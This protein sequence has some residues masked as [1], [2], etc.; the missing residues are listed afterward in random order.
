MSHLKTKGVIS[1]EDVE[2]NVDCISR[3]TPTTNPLNSN[4]WFPWDTEP[5]SSLCLPPIR[6]KNHLLMRHNTRCVAAG[7]IWESVQWIAQPSMEQS[8]PYE[9]WR[10]C[11]H[12]VTGGNAMVKAAI[13]CGKP[14]LGRCRKHSCVTLKN[15]PIS[16]KQHTISSCSL[17]HLTMYGSKGV[18]TS[19][20]QWVCWKNS[21]L[22]LTFVNKEVLLEEFCFGVKATAKTVRNWMRTQ[23]GNQ[24]GRWT[25]WLLRAS[26][27]ISLRQNVKCW[28][29][30]AR[31]RT[32]T[33][34]A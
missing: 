23:L 32:K 20:Y 19:G 17:N 7:A 9:P 31:K 30:G 11:D 34:C 1:E 27:L 25:S 4:H 10:S 33:R 28:W 6:F 29:S 5:S 26:E 16:A 22:S 8:S 14:A 12:P 24:H 21:N 13:P 2:L 18:W 15:Q 3:I